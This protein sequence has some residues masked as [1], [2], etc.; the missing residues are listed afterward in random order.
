MFL[1]NNS[2]N[3]VINSASITADTLTVRVN[4]ASVG[5]TLY[6]YANGNIGMGNTSPADKLSINGTLVTTGNAYVGS[7]ITLNSNGTITATALNISGAIT[8]VGTTV[9]SGDYNPSG[10]H[11]Y[12]LGNTSSRWLVKASTVAANSVAIDNTLTVNSTFTTMAKSITNSGVVAN[13]IDTFSATQFRSGEYLVQ[14]SN[15]THWQ[16]SK[17][18]IL[19]N[20]PAIGAV[21]A[22]TE[23][24]ILSSGALMG[25]LS[26]SI[27]TTDINLRFTASSA[28][29]MTIKIVRHLVVV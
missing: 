5:T 3:T 7:S 6:V 15:S 18:L 8:S 16:S 27:S 29:V 10:D 14:V 20:Y 21:S 11:L 4:T 25:T 23:Y 12:S 22:I 24:G 26:T 19:H 9:S 13:T 17:I 2:V 1:G 28:G